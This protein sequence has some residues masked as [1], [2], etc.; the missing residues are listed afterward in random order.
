MYT[1]DLIKIISSQ[2]SGLADIQPDHNF[3]E[4]GMTSLQVVGLIAEIENT[5]DIQFPDSMINL[6]TFSSVGS[7]NNGLIKLTKKV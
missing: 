7:I 4:L 1:S 6:E 2:I 3:Y 5:F